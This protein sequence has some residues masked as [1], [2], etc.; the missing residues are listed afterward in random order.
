MTSFF[1][2]FALFFG[3]IFG[4]NVVTFNGNNTNQNKAYICPNN[5]DCQI[6]CN[7]D[8]VCKDASFIC[9]INHNCYIKCAPLD[10]MNKFACQGSIIIATYTRSLTVECL[11]WGCYFMVINMTY[12]NNLTIFEPY[13]GYEAENI[14]VTSMRSMGMLYV[15]I[16]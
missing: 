14:E 7:G 6:I 11:N 5:D 2:L 3:N 1:I 13:K 4:I 16:K 15:H 8:R 12:G 9:P 10:I